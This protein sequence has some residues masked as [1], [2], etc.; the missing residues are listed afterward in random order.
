MLAPIV[1]WVHFH[2]SMDGPDIFTTGM[3]DPL[4]PVFS[5]GFLD[6]HCDSSVFCLVVQVARVIREAAPS[7]MFSACPVPRFAKYCQLFS[8]PAFHMRCDLDQQNYFSWCFVDGL[9]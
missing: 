7:V 5:L 1:C 2:V 4:L 3:V 9:K 8:P 6:C